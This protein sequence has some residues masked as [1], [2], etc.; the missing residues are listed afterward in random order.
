M[1]Y[2]VT[3]QIRQI[4]ERFIHQ[5]GLFKIFPDTRYGMNR[6]FIAHIV[7]MKFRLWKF[8]ILADCQGLNQVFVKTI[9][10]YRPSPHLI[11][12]IICFKASLR[13]VHIFA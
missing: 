11:N 10:Q 9:V 1:V 4:T 6:F 5:S 12:G 7:Q 8:P 3:S 13:L 2:T